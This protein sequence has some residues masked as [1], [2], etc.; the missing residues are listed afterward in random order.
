MIGR[1]ELTANA[2]R[3]GGASSTYH[4]VLVENETGQVENL[5]LTQTELKRA[6]ERA[7]KN[8]EDTREV[9]LIEGLLHW[10][11]SMLS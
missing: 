7:G 6:R 5:L 8:E 9:T 3:K 11:C 1:L 2:D 10:L 4:R